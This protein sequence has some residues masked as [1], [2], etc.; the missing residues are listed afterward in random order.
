MRHQKKGR[1][2]G[3]TASHRKALLCNLASSLIVH[4]KIKTTTAK[5]K[6]LRSFTER[7]ISFAK[8]GD[9]P[10]RRYVRKFIKDRQVLKSLLNDVAPLYSERQGGYTRVIKIGTR[11]GDGASMAFIELV[12]FDTFFKKKR[13]EAI[14]KAEKKKQ[15]EKEAAES[16][17]KEAESSKESS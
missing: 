8:R 11:D 9:I 16:E 7:L 15:K 17:E 5:A 6:E 12:G 14:E 2:L 13:E 1:K 4:K 3:R 10:A